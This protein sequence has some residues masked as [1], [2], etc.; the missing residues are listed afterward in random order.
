MDTALPWQREHV[1]VAGTLAVCD[2]HPS[3]PGV[4]TLAHPGAAAGA[5]RQGGGAPGACGRKTRRRRRRALAEEM[6][7]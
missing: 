2:W 3:L 5:P 1:L 6:V 4:A 7:G